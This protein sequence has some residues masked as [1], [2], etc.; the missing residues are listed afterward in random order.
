MS[1]G[2][3]RIRINVCDLESI[4]S[5]HNWTLDLRSRGLLASEVTQYFRITSEVS[6]SHA[7]KDD[8][9]ICHYLNTFLRPSPCMAS[10]VKREF[11]RGTGPG[12]A[13]T[14]KKALMRPLLS[15]APATLADSANNP[16][17]STDRNKQ[18]GSTHDE[19]HTDGGE[20]RPRTPGGVM[21]RAV[22]DPFHLQG[23]NDYHFVRVKQID[24][25]TFILPVCD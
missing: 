22:D 9:I 23:R 15:S 18:E 19:V 14:C 7:D 4:G 24:G 1:W 2:F 12:D 11:D 3:M 10:T 21:R 13:N 17:I 5:H 8:V 25:K 6:A 16:L 20:R